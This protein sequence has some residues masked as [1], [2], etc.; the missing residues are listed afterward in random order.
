MSGLLVTEAQLKNAR[1]RYAYGI[2]PMDVG[3]FL[4]LTTSNH[5]EVGELCAEALDLSLYNAFGASGETQVM[6]M[7]Q[8][9]HSTGKVKGHEGRHRACAL[10]NDGKNVIH[11]ALYFLDD[12]Y[13]KIRSPETIPTMIHGEFGR[14][15]LFLSPSKIQVFSHASRQD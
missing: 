13:Y 9:E 3:D 10:I 7:L 15:S 4:K 2:Y 12:E 14:G 11:V 6:P 5:K 1:S 8:I